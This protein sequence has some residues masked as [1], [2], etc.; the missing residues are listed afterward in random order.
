MP[1]SSESW[2]TPSLQLGAGE[3]LVYGEGIREFSIMPADHS[4][5]GTAH[6]FSASVSGGM[7]AALPVMNPPD[8]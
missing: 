5:I 1:R 7:E 3:R 6:F 2:R 8:P 4:L